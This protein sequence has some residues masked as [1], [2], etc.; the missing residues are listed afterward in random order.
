M[1]GN[2]IFNYVPSLYRRF[3]P[4]FFHLPVAPERHATCSQCAMVVDDDSPSHSKQHF[5]S[6]R[7]KCCTFY[8]S[9]PNYLVGAL[10]ADSGPQSEE[11]RGRFQRVIQQR[12]GVTPHGVLPPRRYTALYRLGLEAFGRAESM[13]CPFLDDDQGFCTVWDYRTALCNSYFCKFNHGH[14]GWRFWDE[15]KQYLQLTEQILMGYAMDQ[16]G[17]DAHTILTMGLDHRDVLGVEDLDQ[18]APGEEE[19]AAI[20]GDWVGREEEFYRRSHE[21]VLGVDQEAFERLGGLEHSLRLKTL[22][23]RYSA[24]IN[25]ETPHVLV[26]NPQLYGHPSGDGSVLLQGYSPFDPR[27]VRKEIYDIFDRFDGERPWREVVAAIHEEGGPVVSESL[28]TLLHQH[29]ILIE[30]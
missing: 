26:R 9:T 11:G 16:E 22:L 15:F 12:I 24:M 1:S 28:I 18:V 29:R 20:W 23:S 2:T 5:F 17:F 7:V 10:L 14:D 21:I 3:F 8:P 30:E 19:Y 13:M 6:A 4:T 27:R 25:P